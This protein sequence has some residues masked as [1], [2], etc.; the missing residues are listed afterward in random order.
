MKTEKPKPEPRWIKTNHAGVMVRHEKGCPAYRDLRCRCERKFRGEVWNSETKRPVKQSPTVANINEA[1]GWVADYR[2]G[3]QSPAPVEVSGV[4]VAEFFATFM[5]AARA[6]TALRK[7]GKR[8]ASR[9]LDKYAR[10]FRHHVQPQAG[11]KSV[12]VMD[13]P[14]W[15]VVVEAIITTGQRDHDGNPTGREF[16]PDTVNT[17]VAGIRA[18]YRWGAAPARRIVPGN[19]L[20]EVQIPHGG[21]KSHTKRVCAPEAIPT[22]LDALAHQP[23]QRGPRPNPAMRVAWAIMFYAGLRVSEVVA[24]DWTNVDLRRG[25][26]TVGE[27][28]SDAG[29]GRVVPIAAP[30]ARILTD[31]RGDVLRVGPVVTGTRTLRAT[32][33]GVASAAKA[34]KRA[35]L[36]VFS[37]HEARHTFASTVIASRDVSLADLKEWLGH[38]SLATTDAY[39]RTLPGY[40]SES[41]GA[42]ISGAFG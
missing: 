31:W 14:A 11:A 28:K 13:A 35:G 15:Q 40:R 37:P 26:V 36:P 8:Y 17:I 2:R 42:R 5:A 6:G 30:L 12:A 20:R 29:T 19:P 1:I 3:V 25:F 39:V 34:W 10:D 21:G 4:T 22:M 9:T 41:A 23:V 24:L 18:A 33:S 32:D 38:A 7:G 16:G 27:S